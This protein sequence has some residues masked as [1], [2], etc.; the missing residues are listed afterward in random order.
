[1]FFWKKDVKK[2][3]SPNKKNWTEKNEPRALQFC[4]FISVGGASLDGIPRQKMI[5]LLLTVINNL[6]F[7]FFIAL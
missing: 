3:K 1:M 5:H 4:F 2:K 6:L 7:V